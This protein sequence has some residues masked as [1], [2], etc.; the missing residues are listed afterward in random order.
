MPSAQLGRG[1]NFYRIFE[2]FENGKYAL[3][4]CKMREP[5]IAEMR[6]DAWAFPYR[7]V[8]PLVALAVAYGFEV[9]GVNECGRFET[10]EEWLGGTE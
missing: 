10:R 5:D 8:G 1:W 3:V 7:G 4:S 6:I 9:V 2:S